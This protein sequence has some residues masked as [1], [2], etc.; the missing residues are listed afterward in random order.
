MNI[1]RIIAITDTRTYELID[2]R[3][4]PIPGSGDLATC[5]RCRRTHE[6]H[7][8]V[9]VDVDGRT[10]TRIVGTGCAS[11]ESMVLAARF[12]SGAS[13]AK[14]IARLR[15]EAARLERLRA[16]V[17]AAHARADADPVPECR[18]ERPKW[19]D[20]LAVVCGDLGADG[21]TFD[22]IIEPCGWQEIQAV[23]GGTVPEPMAERAREHWRREHRRAAR[24][25][26]DPNDERKAIGAVRERLT[27]A[28]RRLAEMMGE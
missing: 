4:K 6:V 1:T 7:A 20:E 15:A 11:K 25:G 28:E 23:T 12:R 24:R 2:D 3:W 19:R 22:T 10:E 16:E 17:D 5:D 27:K 14:T 26:I 21:H 9:E 18:I 8:T 13:T